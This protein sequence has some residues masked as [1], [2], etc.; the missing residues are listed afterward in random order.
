MNRRMLPRRTITS[1]IQVPLGWHETLPHIP[2]KDCSG[3][4][5]H[6]GNDPIIVTSHTSATLEACFL[7][8]HFAHTILLAFAGLLRTYPLY[9]FFY[10]T[11]SERLAFC[12]MLSNMH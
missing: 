11:G 10:R 5:Y 6:S 3:G 7:G 1:T 12:V 2:G 8:T 4:R 9:C